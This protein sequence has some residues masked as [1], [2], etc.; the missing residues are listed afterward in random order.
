M[1]IDFFELIFRLKLI[2]GILSVIFFAL[3]V[4]F[5]VKFQKLVGLKLEML[6]S[7][8]RTPEAAKG[9]AVQSKWEEIKRHMESTREAEWKFAVV[10]ADKMV[11]DLLKRAGY[12]GDSMGERLMNIEKG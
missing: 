10:E 1:N 4:F 7:L 9:G 12:L 8:I 2:S 3:A 11:D 6:K 5:I